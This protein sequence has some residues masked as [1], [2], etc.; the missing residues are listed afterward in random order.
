MA[1]ADV[2]GHERVKGILS[3]ALRQGRLPPALL[4]S[5]PEGVGKKLL[6]LVSGRALVCERGDGDTCGRCAACGRAARGL[7]P[8]LALVE[9]DGATIKIDRVREVARE[10]GGRPF[11]ARARAFVIDEAHLLTEQAANAL[12]KS[13]EEP[14]PTSHVLLVSAAPQ[15]LLPTIRS[16]CQALRVGSLPPVLLAEHLVKTRGLPADEARL[17]A[18]L[19][20]G[21]LGAALAFEPEAYRGLRDALLALLEALPRQGPLDRMEAAER[22][23]DVEDLAL[24][25]TALRALLRD[26]AALG[27]SVPERAVLNAD[28]LPRLKALAA[29]PLGRRAA[30]LAC[31]VGET[32]EALRTN[33]NRLLSM[34]VL[35]EMM[36]SPAAA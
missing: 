6:A 29:G 30:D 28:V 15:A 5:G 35:L 21:S 25:L 14:C 34:D 2:L 18:V 32:R 19:S 13:L 8:D 12:L 22:L 7:H 3:V 17:R 23:A 27:A 36:A 9:P 33:A 11:E 26:V 1:F 20:G 24:A 16:R 31:T 10:I 4:L